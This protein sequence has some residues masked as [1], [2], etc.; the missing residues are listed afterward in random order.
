MQEGNFCM[1]AEIIGPFSNYAIFTR[2]RLVMRSWDQLC[3]SLS[4]TFWPSL[5]TSQTIFCSCYFK[6]VFFRIQRSKGSVGNDR[7][8]LSLVF[9]NTHHICLVFL[10]THHNCKAFWG[11][12]FFLC[13]A[14]IFVIWMVTQSLCSLV[15][16]V[17]LF[18]LF[19]SNILVYIAYVHTKHLP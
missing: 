17:F 5:D 13:F 7:L 11:T 14:I 4:R 12:S 2:I 16:V 3:A 10:N 18:F 1:W 8:I 19:G 15:Y 9:P 6:W